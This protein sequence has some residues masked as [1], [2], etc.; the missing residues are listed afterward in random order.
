MLGVEAGRV[1]RLLDG[2]AMMHHAQEHDQRPLVLLFAAR[3]AEGHPGLAVAQ[4]EAG[5][6]G[7][8]R[9]LARGEAVGQAGT[10]PE[11]LAARAE[12]EAE[13]GDDRARIA[14][15]RPRAWR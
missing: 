14:A 5:R 13:F 15:S 8:A 12:A 6:Q 11:H 4:R 1:D 7:R 10:Q 9:A 2:H 3:R